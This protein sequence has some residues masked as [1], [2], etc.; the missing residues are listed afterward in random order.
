[1]KTLPGEEAR[2]KKKEGKGNKT[3]SVD[4]TRTADSQATAENTAAPVKKETAAKT[5]SKKSGGKKSKNKK[6]KK[7]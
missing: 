3:V 5:S 1:M 4:Q 6:K 7:R 2:K